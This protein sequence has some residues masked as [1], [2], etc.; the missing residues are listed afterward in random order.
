[1]VIVIVMTNELDTCKHKTVPNPSTK[2]L[3]T[4]DTELSS[5]LHRRG[6][7][8]GENFSSSI[9]GRCKQGEFGI[10][11]QMDRLEASGLKGVFFVDP[12][13]ALVYGESIVADIVAPIIARHHEVQLH[14]H[15]EWLEWAKT[16]PVD[17]RQGR[18]LADFTLDDQILLLNLAADLLQRA[19][20]PR[21]TA[22]R[23]GNFGANDDSLRALAKIGLR[24]D[25][26]VNAA[27]LTRGCDI[28]VS[29]EQIDP[30]ECYGVIE[31]PV[32]GLYDRPGQ[33]RPAQICALSIRE[34][35]AALYHA[36]KEQQDH[37]VIVTHSFEMLS[38]DRSRSND[39]VIARF[40]D[41]CRTI[42]DHSLLESAGFNDLPDTVLA[43]PRGFTATRLAPSLPRTV[44]RIIQQALSTWRYERQLRPV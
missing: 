22:F 42:A 39:S 25:S 35:R 28:N 26:S 43:K 38:R 17:G 31:L 5:S 6:H 44:E 11:W 24:W 27:Y 15:T 30:I 8:S 20:A 37:F 40:E 32:S 9:L 16:S 23:A 4:V 14:I 33:M 19:G 2:V 29:A 7:T 1:M 21:A 12:L 34:M 41:M 13:P 10:A 18:N 3:I 36:A